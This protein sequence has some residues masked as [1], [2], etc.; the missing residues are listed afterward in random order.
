[1]AAAAL[2]PPARGEGLTSPPVLPN[3][4]SAPNTVEVNL[5][6]E[7]AR[8][9]L[10][11]G[12]ETNVWAYNGR[13]PGPTLEAH[14][15]DRVIIHFQNNLP[16]PT[17][18]HWHG[19][20]VPV[21]ADGNPMDPIPPGGSYDY[22][23]TL[24][25]GSAGTYW[26][27]PHPH[28]QTLWQ[29]AHGLFGAIIVRAPDDPL[30]ASIPEKLLILWDNRINADGSLDLPQFV[31]RFDL[32]SGREGNVLFVNDQIQPTLTIRKGEVQRWRIINAAA[33]RYFRLS[34]PGHTLLYVGS[35]AGLF[36]RPVEVSD[37]LLA[38]AERVE[39]LVRGTGDPGSAAILQ[40]L[41]Y[42]RYDPTY[43]PTDWNTTHNLL[44][45]QY[46]TEEPIAPPAIP[47][48]L[49]PVAALDPARA[50]A[51]RKIDFYN[52]LIN[53]KQFSLT[54]VDVTAKL[55]TTEV[56]QILNPNADDHPFHLHGFSFQ[57]LDSKGVPIPAW[58]DTVNVPKNGSVRI[59]VEFRDYPGKRMFH[60]HILSHEDGGMMGIL[61]V[62]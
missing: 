51:T 17:T 8:V 59:V 45:L 16:E 36:E 20:H 15:G 5:T 11:P 61:E 60:C 35:D 1:V 54:R 31:S 55:N 32:A 25:P 9:T 27:H 33:G 23:F 37:I 12:T 21:E 22:V 34:L 39:L 48:T 41:P 18:I 29:T 46:S 24:K 42:D 62:Q 19:L 26:Y 30:P 14:E 57:V 7:P 43:R 53:G 58:E 3:L 44:T 52:G 47:T 4:S 50:V 38:S 10:V 56:W 2:A 6:A 40:S 13:V 28:Q 49:R